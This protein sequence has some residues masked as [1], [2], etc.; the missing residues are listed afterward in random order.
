MVERVKKIKRKKVREWKRNRE[1]NKKLEE[2]KGSREKN[3]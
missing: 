1:I 2:K 3:S